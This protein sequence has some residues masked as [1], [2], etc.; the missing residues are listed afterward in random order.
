MVEA[1][2]ILLAVAKQ[3]GKPRG[4]VRVVGEGAAIHLK[5]VNVLPVRQAVIIA[6][7]REHNEVLAILVETHGHVVIR[8]PVVADA[9]LKEVGAVVVIG[10]VPPHIS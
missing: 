1:N 7:R 8:H 10:G 5:P 2:A 9:P 4:V 6:H 3:M